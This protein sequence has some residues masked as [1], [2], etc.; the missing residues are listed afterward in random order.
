[1]TRIRLPL[2]IAMCVSL[3][4][5]KAEVESRDAVTPG[6]VVKPSITLIYDFAVG[7]DDVQVDQWD[8]KLGSAPRRV[9]PTEKQRQ[10]GE[11]ISRAFTDELVKN[12]NERGIRAKRD[13]ATT[14]VPVNA[15]LIQGVFLAIDEGDELKRTVVGLGQGNSR[16][17]ARMRAYQQGATGRRYL[18]MGAVTAEGS[19]KPGI[20]VS[21]ASA[22]ATGSVTGLI[23]TGAMKVGAKSGTDDPIPNEL[24]DGARADVVRAARAVGKRIEAKYREH[25]LI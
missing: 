13:I 3:A 18:G 12:L 6:S 16:V 21:G 22:A 15:I 10:V 5:A 9:E 19:R 20:M 1:M 14:P 24:K 23:F 25:G 4:C 17:Q 2:V 8:I 7:A 11:R